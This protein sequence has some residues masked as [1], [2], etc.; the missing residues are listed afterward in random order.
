MMTN[1]DILKAILEEISIIKNDNR[2]F[3]N[4]ILAL[5]NKAKIKTKSNLNQRLQNEM[6]AIDT[7]YLAGIDVNKPETG[8]ETLNNVPLDD[9][10]NDI[11]L[12]K[13][14]Q[15]YFNP[16]ILERDLKKILSLLSYD[17]EAMTTDQTTKR[18]IYKINTIQ[19][20]TKYAK[21]AA[22]FKPLDTPEKLDKLFL[23][24]LNVIAT[25]IINTDLSYLHKKCEVSH[26]VTKAMYDCGY[27]N[28]NVIINRTKLFY[29]VVKFF[30]LNEDIEYK[31]THGGMNY[32]DRREML[33]I[34]HNANKYINKHKNKKL[35]EESLMNSL[36]PNDIKIKA[37]KNIAKHDT[38]RDNNNIGGQARIK[39]L[40]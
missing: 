29:D 8:L 26:F 39:K 36:L 7:F 13:C 20:F 24:T 18:R 33:K 14:R 28:L 2:N 10:A 32:I 1:K 9:Y 34:K 38:E 21:K 5:E 3:N 40:A 25:A 4:R 11:S 22:L 17:Q 12:S 30:N 37:V 35:K 19:K 31:V 6:R 15:K 27:T 16:P 23:A